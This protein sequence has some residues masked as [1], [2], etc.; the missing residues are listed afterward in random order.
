MAKMSVSI[1]A[2][3]GLARRAYAGG[4]FVFTL[5]GAPVPGYLRSVEGGTITG[6]VIDETVGPDFTHF[7]HLGTVSIEPLTLEL[8]M[9][10]SRPIFDWISASWKRDFS[11]RSGSVVHTDARYESQV[12]QWFTDALIVET[13]FPALDGASTDPAY[14][15]VKLQPEQ[16]ELKRGDGQ[17]VSSV[18]SP[19]QKHWSPS[20]FRLNIDGLDTSHVS[21]ID[22]FSVT[23]K[24]K[25]LYV[26]SARFPEL[27]P[28]GL[29]FSNLTVYTSLA[30]ADDFLAWYQEVLADGDKDT[31]QE[32]QGAIEFL[33]PNRKDTLFTV[34]LHNV[35]IFGFTI[36]KSEAG[37][38]RPKR[39]KIDLYVESMS[40]EYG[41]GVA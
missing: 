21:K 32:R 3:L 24:L 1:S 17:L 2:G 27:E 28:T 8:G 31:R 38:D 36:E 23:Q 13:T 18:I 12:E 16:V 20:N 26:G 30:H 4:H 6:E 25:E 7:K 40:L 22:S 39:C 41:A 19:M 29:E 15:T 33:G 9:S 37:A 34:G 35:G 10:M 5:D 14:L 11:R